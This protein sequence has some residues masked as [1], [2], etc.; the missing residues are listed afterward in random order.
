MQEVVLE[1]TSALKTILLQK[2]SGDEDLA[3]RIKL[4]EDFTD[5]NLIAFVRAY[6]ASGIKK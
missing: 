4:S 5:L 2:L 6:N 1:N 3:E